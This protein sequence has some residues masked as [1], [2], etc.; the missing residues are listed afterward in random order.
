MGE[1]ADFNDRE[2]LMALSEAFLTWEKE[3]ETQTKITIALNL[4]RENISLETIARTTGLTIE[5]VQQLQSQADQ[6]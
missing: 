1:L 5:Q 3:K 2:E 4:L 6:N